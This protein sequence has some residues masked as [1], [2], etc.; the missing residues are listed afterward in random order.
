MNSEMNSTNLTLLGNTLGNETANLTSSTQMTYRLFI[1]KY[2]F[3][4][5]C[6]SIFIIIST[7]ALVYSICVFSKKSGSKYSSQGG[8]LSLASAGAS[9]NASSA[10]PKKKKKKKNKNK[11]QLKL[12]GSA[13]EST[14]SSSDSSVVQDT[15]MFK[16]KTLSQL[17][18]LG[19]K[20][21]KKVNLAVS[22]EDSDSDEG[23][24]TDQVKVTPKNMSKVSKILP[25]KSNTKLKNVKLYYKILI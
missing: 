6:I 16:A 8:D 20:K 5:V 7:S 1:W 4:V 24:S 11:R 22:S 21:K 25:L 14:E 19:K 12:K 18:K 3:I 23:S 13:K 2:G 10:A 15:V 9:S 17:Q